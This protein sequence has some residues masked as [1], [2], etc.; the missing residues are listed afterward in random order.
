MCDRETLNLI[1]KSQ[2]VTAV[3]LEILWLVFFYMVPM[4]V[5]ITMNIQMLI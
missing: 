2:I 5:A 3:Y 4:H 1:K